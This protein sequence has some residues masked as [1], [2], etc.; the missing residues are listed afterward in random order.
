MSLKAFKNR[1]FPPTCVKPLF[2]IVKCEVMDMKMIFHS[3]LIEIKLI[4]PRKV[5][6]LEVAF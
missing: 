6:Y 4:F 5:L 3:H 2:Q 1:T